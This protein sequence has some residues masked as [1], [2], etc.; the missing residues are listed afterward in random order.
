VTAWRQWLDQHRAPAWAPGAPPPPT[1]PL[2]KAVLLDR[3]EQ[4]TKH[5]PTCSKVPVLLLVLKYHIRPQ[6]GLRLLAGLRQAVGLESG[7]SSSDTADA[8]LISA[9]SS[10]V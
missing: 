2:S 8:L 6:Q 7:V 5:C 9:L 4:H 3:Y 10:V 1:Q